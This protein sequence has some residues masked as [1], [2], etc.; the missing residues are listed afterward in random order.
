LSV[1]DLHENTTEADLIRKPQWLA[2][3]NRLAKK[4]K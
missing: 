4:F 3:Q 1:A 2:K